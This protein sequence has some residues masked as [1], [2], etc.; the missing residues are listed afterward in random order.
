MMTSSSMPELWLTISL[1]YVCS[2][3]LLE[4]LSCNNTFPV[5]LGISYLDFIAGN[6]LL[7]CTIFESESKNVNSLPLDFSRIVPPNHGE[8]FF[9]FGIVADPASPAA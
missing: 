4:L 3:F 9:F 8:L 1:D 2:F 7:I 6:L 5:G